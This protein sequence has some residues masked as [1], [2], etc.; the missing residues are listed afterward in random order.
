MKI[1][2]ESLSELLANYKTRPEEAR[3]LIAVGE[4]RPDST[5]DAPTLATWTMLVNELMNL[6]EVLNK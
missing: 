3:K 5:L 4:S 2:Q 1:V 6:A